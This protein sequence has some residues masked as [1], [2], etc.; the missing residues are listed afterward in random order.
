MGKLG[1]GRNG[2]AGAR[3]A[4]IFPCAQSEVNAKR[5]DGQAFTP[6][7]WPCIVP[8]FRRFSSLRPTMRRGRP[9]FLKQL[10]RPLRWAPGLVG[11]A[12]ATLMA[13]TG[14]CAPLAAQ[15]VLDVPKV[16]L[17]GVPFQL[18]VE[19]PA[20]AVDPDVPAVSWQVHDAFGDELAR[21]TIDAHATARTGDLIV[22][23]RDQLPLTVHVGASSSEVQPTLVHG[24]FSLAPPLVAI[25]LALL[26]REVVTALLAGVWLGS[27]AVAGFNP[28]TAIWRTIDTYIVPAIADTSHASIIVFSMLL[29]GMVGL[30]SRMGGTLGIVE[31]VAPFARSPRRGKLATWAAGLAI[32]FDDYANTLLVGNTMRPITDRL[33]ISREKL[34]YL[35]DSTA[36]PVAALVPVS[37]WV[38]YEISLIGDGIAIA[39][40]QHAGE[41]ELLAQLSSASPFAVFLHT[42]PYLFY[43]LLALAFVFFTSYFNRDFGAMARAEARAAEGRGLFREGAQLAVDTGA[44]ELEPKRGATPRWW[45]AGIPVLAVV[46]VVLGGLWTTGRSSAGP[47]ASLMDI[48]GA[49]DP[50]ATL[51]WGSLAGCIVAFVLAV[52]QR[53]L[54]MAEAIEAWMGGLKS[55][56]VAMVILTLAWSLG[57]ITETLHTAAFLSGLLE[58]NLPLQLLPWAVFVTAAAMA[59]ATGTSWGTMAILLPLVIPLTVTLGGAAGF[60]GGTHYS[61]L[62]GAISSVLAGA[63]FGDHCSPISDTTVLSSM[64]SA[65]DHVDHVRTQ[66]PYAFVVALVSMSLGD[67]GTAYGLPNW[68]ALALGV[69]VLGLLVRFLGT[70]VPVPAPAP[71]HD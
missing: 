41:T 11:T 25:V 50:F 64:A 39:Q 36:A 6:A 12:C 7:F 49:A 30:M 34:A 51:L 35:V 2:H 44:R 58:G 63:I 60:D 8:Y 29:G 65:C 17:T 23:A 19:G 66:L 61:V 4:P 15:Q 22:R 54:T 26:F 13:L 53:L 24:G 57:A 46:A 55:M 71:A 47:E 20:G 52:S 69:I 68:I 28:L 14:V 32:F 5:H 67:I 33:R 27:L 16:V 62:L 45:N 9:P 43:P 40:A 1:K 42:I 70:P 10:T 21:G 48:F 31:A 38:G 18:T 59:F 3:D 37:T 56:V